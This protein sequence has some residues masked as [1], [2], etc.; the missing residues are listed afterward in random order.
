MTRHYQPEGGG[1]HSYAFL[2]ELNVLE[3][4]VVNIALC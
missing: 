4:V 2:F 1:R 3:I